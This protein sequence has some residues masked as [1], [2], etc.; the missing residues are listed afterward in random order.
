MAKE[1]LEELRILYDGLQE[2]RRS[3]LLRLRSVAL[4]N[5]ELRA[6]IAGRLASLRKAE[7]RDVVYAIPNVLIRAGSRVS[8]GAI[9]RIERLTAALVLRLARQAVK[10]EQWIRA[11]ILYQTVAILRPRIFLWKQVGN[12][13]YQQKVYEEAIPL[14]ESVLEVSP[15]DREA[16]FLLEQC[17]GRG[18]N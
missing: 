2:Q 4:E 10:K 18:S 15:D 11:Q 3:D 9:T 5:E 14:L 16:I 13:L 6:D 1:E 8:H 12:M 17:K 7:P